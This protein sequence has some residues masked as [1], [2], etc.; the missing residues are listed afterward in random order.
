MIETAHNARFAQALE[1]A[2]I[3]RANAF[4]AVFAWLFARNSVPLA[5]QGL[6]EPCR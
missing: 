3:E 6:T 4:R 5:P 2:H 1:A